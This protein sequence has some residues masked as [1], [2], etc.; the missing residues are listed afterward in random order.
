MAD[1]KFETFVEKVDD[2][3]VTFK[4]YEPI[5]DDYK[6]AAKAR[7]IAFIEALVERLTVPYSQRTERQPSS[8]S[9]FSFESLVIFG[10][11]KTKSLLS[12]T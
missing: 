12:P 9:F 6:E 3:D 8:T 7:N 4:V 5:I 10:F 1:R 11:M 2:K